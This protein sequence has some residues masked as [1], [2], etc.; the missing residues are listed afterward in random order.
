MTSREKSRMR[1]LTT[2]T[3]LAGNVSATIYYAGVVESGGEFSVWSS[4]S[5]VDSGLPGRFGVEYQFLNEAAIDIHE[6]QKN[7]VN[8]FRVAF[9]L[10]RRRIYNNPSRQPTTGSIIGD[11]TV[12]IAATTTQFA[13]FWG[14]IAKRFKLNEKVLFGIMNE[15]L[16]SDFSGG[17]T[18]FT[19]SHPTNLTPLT[20]W[21]KQYGFKAMITGFD[22][23]NGAQ[24]L[25]YV[26]DLV[27][28]MAANEEH[29][30]WTRG[31]QANN[32]LF[33]L[34]AGS[35]WGAWK[36]SETADQH[37]PAPDSSSPSLLSAS[38][39]LMV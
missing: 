27:K 5:A 7:K 39:P 16:D 38:A 25:G 2:A 23:A 21:L 3:L 24:C 14:E 15:Y 36:F 19:S 32:P 34:G 6:D 28:Y 1:F 18:N 26:T 11:A 13:A 4:T 10:E 29:I 20:A 17:H 12:G 33:S 30:G 8:L 37:T 22:A 35:F 31:L 9:L